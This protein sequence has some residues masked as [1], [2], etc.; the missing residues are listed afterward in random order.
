MFA[1]NSSKMMKTKFKKICFEE[2]LAEEQKQKQNAKMLTIF[3]V[4]NK[5]T[6][7]WITKED[8]NRHKGFF[9]YKKE[10]GTQYKPAYVLI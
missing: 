9:I 7:H 5:Y 1:P 10:Y 3:Y 8:V 6:V 4:Y 2:S